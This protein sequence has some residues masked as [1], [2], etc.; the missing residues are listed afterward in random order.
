MKS[1]IYKKMMRPAMTY[2]S[3]CLTDKP[4]SVVIG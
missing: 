2:G 3:E 1:E 4:I